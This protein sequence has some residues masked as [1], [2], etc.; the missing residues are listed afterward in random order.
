M[1]IWS[2]LLILVA[3]AFV[4]NLWFFQKDIQRTDIGYSTFISGR[5]T[6]INR[7]RGYKIYL[8]D[9]KTPYNFDNFSN[10][11]ISKNNGLGYYVDFKDSIYKQQNSDTLCLIRNGNVSYWT[12]SKN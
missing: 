3:F 4:I 5:V 8:D 12:L 7:A 1:R 2:Y 9:T 10:D 6:G 11:I